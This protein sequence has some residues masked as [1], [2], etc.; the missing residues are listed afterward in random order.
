MNDQNRKELVQYRLGRAKDTLLEVNLHVDNELWNT[1]VNRL[2]Y[3]CYYA[4]TALLVSEEIIT[5]T[6]A[7]GKANVWVTLYKN[8]INR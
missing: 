4:V 8:R 1:A 3:A 2:Y 5:Q 7:R 6:H